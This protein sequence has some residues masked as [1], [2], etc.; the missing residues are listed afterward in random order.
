ML[1]V[2]TDRINPFDRAKYFL[3]TIML[4]VGMSIQLRFSYKVK[5]S[6]KAIN[7]TYISINYNWQNVNLISFYLNFIR[8]VWHNLFYKTTA[9]SHVMEPFPK[10]H[11]D[12]RVTV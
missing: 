1:S 8:I 9:D 5:H 11:K 3:E 12:L 7:N 2:R 10:S 4:Q 6:I